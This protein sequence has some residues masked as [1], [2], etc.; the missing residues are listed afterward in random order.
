MYYNRENRGR[1]I[2]NRIKNGH[3]WEGSGMSL[4]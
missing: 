4:D 3:K 1:N 2:K